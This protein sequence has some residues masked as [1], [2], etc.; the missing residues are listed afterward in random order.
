M[1]ARKAIVSDADPE[2]IDDLEE[3][4]RQD[5]GLRM[6]DGVGDRQQAERAHRAD[7]GGGH[8]RMVPH[9]WPIRLGQSAR[10][11]APSVSDGRV[12]SGGQWCF[13]LGT[14]Y[15]SARGSLWVV[16]VPLEVVAAGV[17]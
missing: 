8:P 7:L 4:Q 16:C 13:F 14:S 12:G 6:V 1:A 17:T 15:R 5:D 11:A 9:R 10:A 3:D 2:L